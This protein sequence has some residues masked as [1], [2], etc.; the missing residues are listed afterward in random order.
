MVS[1][2]STTPTSD[3]SLRK[4]NYQNSS[5]SDPFAGVKIRSEWV[6]TSQSRERDSSKG[7]ENQSINELDEWSKVCT[8]QEHLYFF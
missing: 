5:E 6:C 3:Y 7:S 8:R 2:F 4:L 1:Q